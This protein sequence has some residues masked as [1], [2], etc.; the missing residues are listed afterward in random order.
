MRCHF[1]PV[2]QKPIHRSRIYFSDC[3]FLYIDWTT[4]LDNERLCT[5]RDE[6]SLRVSGVLWGIATIEREEAERID[7]HLL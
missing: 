3:L 5:S 7:W 2:E 4:A 6:S 1:E